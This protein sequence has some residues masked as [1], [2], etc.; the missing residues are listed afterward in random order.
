MNSA[1]EIRKTI[2][3]CVTWLHDHGYFGGLL[4]TGGN[5]SVRVP[6]ERMLVITPSSRPYDNLSPGELC[7]LDFDRN[8][9]EGSLK[10]SIETGMHIGIYEKRPDVG[11]IVHTHQDFASLF[12]L[13]NRPIPSLFDE[14]VMSIG[15]TVEV[16]PYALSGSAALVENVKSRLENG[17]FCYI[18]Q[19]HGALSLG[20][21]L[22]QAW[23][24]AELLEKT[25]K[26]YYYALSTGQP[27]TTLSAEAIEGIEE[28]KRS[29]G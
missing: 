25:A 5:V 4:S 14:V 24:N 23:K 3:S 28:L 20:A 11:A 8:P 21:T 12:S 16:I 19:N 22:E 13:I 10:P 7:M 27:V 18:I 15:E 1:I 2:V 9:V 6:G 17:C 26:V 29:M